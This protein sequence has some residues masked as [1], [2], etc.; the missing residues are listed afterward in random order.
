MHD[1]ILLGRQRKKEREEAEE[2]RR[3]AQQSNLL[4]TIFGT[5]GT[6][7]GGT[8]GGPAGAAIG[9][10]LGQL[11][12]S[13]AGG[14]PDEVTGKGIRELGG[15]VN[16]LITSRDL[17]LDNVFKKPLTREENSSFYDQFK[18]DP[19]EDKRRKR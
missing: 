13:S 3:R 10:K 4:G 1:N 5:I 14:G 18:Y 8:F 12:G 11:V 7:I 16:Q 15:V 6:V 19:F 9:G 2:A 17:S